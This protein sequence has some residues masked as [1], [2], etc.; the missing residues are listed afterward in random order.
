MIS[1]LLAENPH[2]L[3]ITEDFNCRSAQWWENDIENNEGKLFEQITADNG[4]HQLISEPKHIV[5]SSKSSIDLI[6]TDQP[7]IL[8]FILH[9]MISVIIKLS[10]ENY[11]FQ[12]YHNHLMS[13]EFGTMIKQI[14]YP[15]GKVLNCLSGMNILEKLHVLMSRSSCS[16]KFF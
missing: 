11:L 6:F 10:M 16:M 1:K 4:L 8:V 5:G 2:C 12:T 15:L 9:Y 7:K 3:M 14:S 13:V